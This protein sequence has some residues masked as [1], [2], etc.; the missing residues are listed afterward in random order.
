MKICPT[1]AVE[2]RGYADFVP[3]GAQVTPIRSSDSIAWTVKFRNQTVKRFKFP[4]RTTP[5][6]AA[7]PDGGF[8]TGTDDLASPVLFTEPASSGLAELPTIKH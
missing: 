7:V 6:G 2:I 8:D 4:I 1:Q 5:E 3:L